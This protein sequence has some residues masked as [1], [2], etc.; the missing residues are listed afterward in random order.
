MNDVSNNSILIVD[1]VP[2]NIDILVGLLSSS[3]TISAARSGEIALKIIR[4]SPPD[5]ILLDIL[6][7][8]MD[9]YEVCKQLRSDP[10]TETIPVVFVSAADSIE[11][12]LK[13][14][15]VGGDDYV[16][17]PF[18]SDELIK[19]INVL[20]HHKNEVEKLASNASEAMKVAMVAM[21]SAGELGN[22]LDFLS[23]SFTCHSSNEL[24][25]AMLDNLYG[26]NLHCAVQIRQGNNKINMSNNG[27]ASP[28]EVAVIDKLKD[29]K[30]IYDFGSRTVINYPHVSLLIK[31]MP[32]DDPDLY[33]R[34]KDNIAILVEGAEERIKAISIEEEVKDKQESLQRIVLM[35]EQALSEIDARNKEHKLAST[36][37]ME[38]LLREIEEAF[39]RLGLTEEQELEMISMANR[40]VE[41]A[42][43]LYEEGLG[44]DEHLFAVMEQ[45]QKSVSV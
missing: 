3:Y 28:L 6:M 16:V 41:K 11:E 22:V 34:I 15:D 33:G 7:P 30:R 25:K 4:S 17:K 20:L 39:L 21:T 35:T 14:Y 2:E 5:L 12:R 26:N 27:I 29:I 38:N 9:G 19:K 43:S 44:V 31:N 1:D 23:K 40:N 8:E 45:L 32:V 37:I 36:Q 42:L 18:N 10:I 13:G 24:A